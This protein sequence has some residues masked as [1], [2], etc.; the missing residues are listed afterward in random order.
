MSKKT[1]ARWLPVA[2]V[3]TT[4]MAVVAGWASIAGQSAASGGE[5]R[6]V[7]S[8]RAALDALEQSGLSNETGR[9]LDID[10]STVTQVGSFLLAS[11]GRHEVY[12]AKTRDGWTCI[13]EER[14]AGATP[15]GEPLGLYGDGCSPAG[16]SEN[17]LRVSVSAAGSVD[18]AGARGLSIVGVAGS[19]IG[20]VEV[21]MTD[22]VVIPLA[23]NAARGFHFAGAQGNGRPA[24]VV[25]FDAAGRKVDEVAVVR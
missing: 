17:S 24:A 2:L 23:M 6:Q 16:S 10:P 14:P 18:E 4:A 11:G 1:K 25:G 15:D 12:R 7:A 3:A 8:P 5:R 21:R 19:A 9:A 13:L 22:G 20:R